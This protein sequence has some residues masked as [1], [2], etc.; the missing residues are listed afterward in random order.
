MSLC[1][2]GPKSRRL[3][4]LLLATFLLVFALRSP[5]T[6]Q[7]LSTYGT[8]GLV[9]MPTAEVLSD[10]ELAFSAA[11]F[12]ATRR[13][14]V[15]FQ[16][17]PWVYGSFRYSFLEDFF[18]QGRGNP[19]N[20]SRYDRSFDLHFQ[21]RHESQYWPAIA[22]GLRDVVGTGVYSG[23]Y[24]VATK[25]I[26]DRLTVTAGMG[27]GRLASRGGFRN[28]LCWNNNRFCTRPPID[29]GEGGTLASTSWFRG[30]AALFGG[31]TWSLNE[32]L[33]LLAEYSSDAYEPEVTE[34]IMK[35]SSP[36]NFGA[37]YK[38]DNGTQLSGYFIQGTELGIQLSYTLDP[39][40]PRNNA[41][42][43]KAPPA[44]IPVNQV[45]LASWNLPKRDESQPGVKQ[46]LAKRLRNEG[47]QLE[48]FSI[49]GSEAIVRVENF[50]Y[51]ASAQAVG[52]ANRAIINTL[53][54]SV[55]TFSVILLRNGVPITKVTTARSDF[56]ELERDLDGSWR[57]LA[58]ADISDA[59][60]AYGGILQDAYPRYSY[61]LGPFLRFSFFD[62]DNPFRADLGVELSAD[63]VVRPGLTFSGQFR[64]PIIGNIDQS[65]RV[66]DSVLPRVRSDWPLYAKAS[67]LEL[68]YLTG[69]YIWRPR[70]D[71]FARVTAGYLEPMYGGLSAE[72][73]WYPVNSRLA[74]G[75]ELNYAQQREFDILFGFRDYGVITGHGSF[76][77][78]F[79]NDIL[80]QLDVGRYLAGDLGAT[81]SLDREFNNGFKV[82][83]FFTLTDVSAEDFGEGSFDKGIRIVVPLS[84]FTGRPSRTNV[85]QVIRPVLR[86]GGARLIVRNRLYEYTR[87]DRGVRM[88]DQW[89]RYFR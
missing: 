50:R 30:D 74:L 34:G 66:S 82:G 11:G 64:Q 52:R 67:D 33:T 22:V 25:S 6:A 44:I 84:W 43:E 32:R 29:F 36:F 4:I 47:L 38:F 85:G 41:G 75:A 21:L 7:N 76:Y 81:F 65:T 78:E 46:V 51:G 61:N 24:L 73:L 77:Y 87:A 89:G 10:G 17:L 26:G 57:S 56:A 9:D 55:Q 48:G 79:G 68:T 69:E 28:P 1:A 59:N 58:R 15:T 27:W 20:S 37:A 35:V 40:K 16:M 12:G 49:V 13:G 60:S 31:L 54:P 42:T 62:P 71:V 8:P 88:A 5:M 3:A 80:G 39:T 18:A 83:G 19:V 72:L 86:D 63:L 14:T 45:A 70:R 23:E 2:D 53:P